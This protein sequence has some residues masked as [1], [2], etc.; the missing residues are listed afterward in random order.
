M[1]SLVKN[2]IRSRYERKGPVSYILNRG[3]FPYILNKKGLLGF[4][5]EVGVKHGGF[6]EYLLQHWRGR[7][8]V[9][10]D[11]WRSFA[12]DEYRDLAN[13]SQEEFDRIYENTSRRLGV[14]GERSRIMR[15]LSVEAAATFPD[16]YFDFVYLD[17]R[18][19]YDGVMEDLI[20]WAPKI[21]EGGVLAGH[22][23]LNGVY[24]NTE[25]GVKKA[26]DEYADARNWRVCVSRREPIYKSW[27]IF[28]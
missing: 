16:R 14:F 24:D 25:F 17:A 22:D 6:S 8:L 7:C 15:C 2:I 13:V 1:I 19:D 23:Y 26:V 5:V 9:S 27:F 10:V 20:A 11:A 21:C 12:S 3:E 28:I 18:H 4:G